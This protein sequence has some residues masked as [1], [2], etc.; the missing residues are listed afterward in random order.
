MKTL[1]LPP[2]SGSTDMPSGI[3]CPPVQT[4]AGALSFGIC[5]KCGCEL[6]PYSYMVY[7]R[8]PRVVTVKTC[9][10]CRN[11]SAKRYQRRHKHFQMAL[12]SRRGVQYP[13][14]PLEAIHGRVALYGHRCWLCGMPY[15]AID[16]VK[17]LAAGGSHMVANLRPICR[18]CN[19]KKR[20]RW[21][22]DLYACRWG[23]EK[24]AWNL[25]FNRKKPNRSITKGVRFISRQLC[26]VFDLRSV[27]RDKAGMWWT[28]IE[29]IAGKKASATWSPS[30]RWSDEDIHGLIS[31][32]VI[33]PPVGEFAG[34][35]W[36]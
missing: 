5:Y 6:V 21:S 12:H 1:E 9:R 33:R 30:P 10:V 24:T 29:T 18:R 26:D 2:V 8:S 32:G 23:I 7:G 27:R 14:L 35:G 34:R 11:E 15:D 31:R 28:C 13:R 17:P 19:S 20:D 22:M 16:H 36:R 4:D 3:V 25:A